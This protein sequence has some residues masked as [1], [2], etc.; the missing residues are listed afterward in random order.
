MTNWT[1]WNKRDKVW[2]SV[3]SLFKWRFR[4]RRR[5]CCSVG[6]GLWR[7]SVLKKEK[8]MKKL[9]LNRAKL[10]S[11]SLWTKSLVKF[12]SHENS[13]RVV[14][15]LASHE[16]IL[17]DSSRVPKITLPLVKAETVTYHNLS[18]HP[19]VV[20]AWECVVEAG[21]AFQWDP[22]EYLACPPPENSHKEW[23]K[24]T[25]FLSVFRVPV[26]EGKFERHRVEQAW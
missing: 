15:T 6:I 3:N 20:E 14:W 19:Q 24:G 4:S 1:R 17:K 25:P 23:T 18:F 7:S 12:F 10:L 8:P 11:G 13:S 2:S 16:D 21:V 9:K 5:C 22:R 26:R